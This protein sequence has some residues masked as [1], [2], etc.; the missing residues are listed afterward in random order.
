MAAQNEE[1]GNGVD[2]KRSPAEFRKE[3]GHQSADSLCPS[4]RIRIRRRSNASGSSRA[5]C[6]GGADETVTEERE[7]MAAEEKSTRVWQC[8][9]WPVRWLGVSVEKSEKSNACE[10]ESGWG[11]E[12]VGRPKKCHSF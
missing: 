11:W 1:R 3:H 2:R 12:F 6:V 8:R 7:F 4:A 9:K 10:E 5:T